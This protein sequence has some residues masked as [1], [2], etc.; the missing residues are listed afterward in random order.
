MSESNV[1]W[2][3]VRLA[4]GYLASIAVQ[5]LFGAF[6]AFTVLRWLEVV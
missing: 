1:N 2:P 6:V 4:A 5:M 3:A